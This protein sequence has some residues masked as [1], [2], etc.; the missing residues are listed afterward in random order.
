MSG[1]LED[2]RAF[3]ALANAGESARITAAQAEA[4]R[5]A[6]RQVAT[7]QDALF[8]AAG[9]LQPDLFDGAE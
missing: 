4:R 5:A 3:G 9:E 7:V 8:G 2:A 6:A 1:A